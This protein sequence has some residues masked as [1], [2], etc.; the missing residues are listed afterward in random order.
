MHPLGENPQAV[1]SRSNHPWDIIR[2]ELKVYAVDESLIRNQQWPLVFCV[3]LVKDLLS[4]LTVSVRPAMCFDK[5]ISCREE[6]QRYSGLREP[7]ASSSDDPS[8]TAFN[9]TDITGEI[10]SEFLSVWGR[11]LFPFIIG[12]HV[13]ISLTTG[14]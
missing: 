13:A 3:E 2:C 4:H 8:L 6:H 11:S 1:L 14:L 5:S 9:G 12:T 10:L 7:K